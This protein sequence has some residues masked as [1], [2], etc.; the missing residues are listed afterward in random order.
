M[1]IEKSQKQRDTRTDGD[2]P[3]L[4]PSCVAQ[5]EEVTVP[6]PSITRNITVSTDCAFCQGQ[7]ACG[8]VACLGWSKYEGKSVL[9][10]YAK[11]RSF[12]P[13]SISNFVMK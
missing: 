3:L 4:R 10:A 11:T 7:G 9:F 1:S 12:R 6:A 8:D 2:L 13:L 5:R